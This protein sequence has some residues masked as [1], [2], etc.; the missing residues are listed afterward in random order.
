MHGAVPRLL[1]GKDLMRPFFE[2]ASDDTIAVSVNVFEAVTYGVV[3][4]SVWVQARPFGVR[5]FCLFC[6]CDASFLCEKYRCF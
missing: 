4:E 3:L 1:E 5:R 2:G 6:N